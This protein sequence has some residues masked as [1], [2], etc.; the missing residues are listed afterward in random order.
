M[1]ECPRAGTGNSRNS[2]T[3][4]PNPQSRNG[5]PACF[6][7]AGTAAGGRGVQYLLVLLALVLTVLSPV[8]AADFSTPLA[9][10][11]DSINRVITILNSTELDRET[12]WQRIAV[13]I[14]DGFD[15]R[16]MSQSVLATHWK[17]ASQE[18]RD[19]FTTFFSQYIEETYREKIEAYSDQEIIYRNETVNGD[20]A[21]VDIAIVTDAVEIPVSFRLKDNGGQWYA[22][23]VVI[24]GVSLVANYRS[25]FAAIVKNEGMPGLMLDIQQRIDR[26]KAR[27]RELDGAAD[28]STPAGDS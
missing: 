26:Y 22:Y 1:A 12:R 3:D 8:R 23:D 10:V 19:Q 2:V 4:F 21:V 20:R 9:R 6:M 18:E 14:D 24:E 25:T 5:L 28:T 27:H 15:F 11:K 17:R 7:R 16:S 13:V